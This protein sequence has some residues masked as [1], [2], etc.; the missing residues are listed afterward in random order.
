MPDFARLPSSWI[1]PSFT[2]MRQTYKRTRA[3]DDV[4]FSSNSAAESQPT[5][6][7]KSVA[8]CI[9]SNAGDSRK[10][11][12]RDESNEGES[13]GSQWT[14]PLVRQSI[15]AKDKK[16]DQ[17]P[18]QGHQSATYTNNITPAS[19]LSASPTLSKA[20][21]QCSSAL[22]NVALSSDN[23]KGSKVAQK[24]TV[25]VSDRKR[26]FMYTPTDV[27]KEKMKKY[28][29]D[30]YRLFDSMR[31]DD[32]WLHPWPPPARRNGRRNGRPEG[33]IQ[34]GF[35]WKDSFG[36]HKLNV[37]V[38]FLA[39]IVEGQLTEEQMEGYVNES[40]HL[41]HL[42]GN[43]ICC[44]WRHMT[45]ESGRTNISRNRCFK[46]VGYCSHEPPCMKHWKRRLLI[47]VDI[48]NHIKSAIKSVSSDGTATA[49]YQSSGFTLDGWNCGICG[50]DTWCLG[51][52][53]ICRSLTSITKSQEALE[54]LKFCT[55]PNDE[56]REAIVY[57]RK[58]IAD[59]SE[60]KKA[61]DKTALE[62]W[63]VKI[64]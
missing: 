49:G 20:P 47:T 26:F 37:N 25:N 33:T 10:Y 18:F 29:Y 22:A 63:L 30:T 62:R 12:A 38:G 15:Y 24:E 34:C 19:N 35:N 64:E 42:C 54:K 51:I 45:V 43:W 9:K 44:N 31:S 50:K 40:W 17:L 32:C 7:Q 57:L 4:G 23:T 48:S 14:Y 53:V 2:G 21:A 46:S 41:S 1:P 39:L 3:D 16:F 59:L 58:I 13:S 61:N 5:K 28:V 56:I 52:F 27:M 11:F 36:S 8:H 60:E 55:Q 6:R